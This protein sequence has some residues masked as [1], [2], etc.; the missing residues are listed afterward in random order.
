VANVAERR[1]KEPDATAAPAGNREFATI[2]AKLDAVLAEQ[3]ELRRLVHRMT[4][5]VDVLQMP[6][7]AQRLGVSPRTVERL[8]ARCVFTD[9]RSPERRLA[10]VARL[11][12]ADELDVYRIE[13]ERGV[14]RLREALGR[15]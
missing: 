7:A 9:A 12:F 6:E 8:A 2:L 10:R 1:T 11:F 14:K 5:V 13:G 3:H 4:V 15:N